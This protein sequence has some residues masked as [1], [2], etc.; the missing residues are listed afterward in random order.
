ML[1][2]I[3]PTD[4]RTWKNL[5]A[6]AQ[7][8]KA[9]HMRDLFKEDSERFSGF[10]LRFEDMLVDYSKNIITGQTMRLLI[11]LTIECGLREAIDLMF[12]GDKINETEK[13]AVLHVAL[14]NRSNRPMLVDGIDVMPEVNR[15]L[16]QMESFSG[17]IISGKWTGYTGKA[18]RHIVNIGI[19]GSDLGPVM[20]TEAL[21]PYWKPDKEAHFVS[22][23]D[24]THI[25]ETLKRIDPE[26]SLFIISSKT[27]TTQETMT[28]AHTAREWFLKSAV[29][30]ERVKKHFVAVSTND[31]KVRE[32]GIDTRNMFRF[33]DWVGGR[34]SLWS[35][36]GL[37]IACTVGFENFRDMLSGAHAMDAHFRSAPFD[38]NIPVILA[39]LGVWYNNFFGAETH[40]ILPYDQYMHRFS[41]YFQQGDMESNGK[42]VDRTGRRVKYQTGPV[43]WGEPGTNGQHAFYQL[44][45]QGTRLVPC[46]F[47]APAISHN[48]VGDHHVKLM[49]NFFA[50]TEALMRG[51]TREEAARELAGQGISKADAERLLPYKIFE[52]NRP[53]NSILVKKITPRTLGS[54]VAMYEHKIFTQGVI[55][56]IF[57][58]D[59]WGV[60]LGKQ[61]AGGILTELGGDTPAV[62]HDSSTNGLINAFKKQRLG[63]GA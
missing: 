44:I 55:W 54:L 21:R 34:Y 47:I 22:N 45:H 51:K 56:N 38:G 7:D 33:W 32:F 63:G 60:E 6:H 11:D 50:Q 2:R 12:S 57:S 31:E 46:D 62:S 58:F 18:I 13:R 10:S 40:A 3:C 59:Q 14:R 5:E 8:M 43:I 41:A 24:G 19:G 9:R 52:G 42:Y 29:D 61:L 25:A 1:D 53:T 49:S 16:D 27:F 36:I 26:T 37:S 48:P 15:V 35:A 20:V 39:L 30:E 28:N 4:T 23:I 17:D